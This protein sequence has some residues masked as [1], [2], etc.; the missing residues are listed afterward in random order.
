MPN[1]FAYI[2]L[3]AWPA[4]ALVL[5]RTLP[6]ERALVWSFMA[7]YMV[8]PEATS[9]DPPLIPPLD[10]SS[11]TNISAFLVCILVMGQKVRILPVSGLGKILIILYIVSPFATIMTNTD[12]F[13]LAV[14]PVFPGMKPYDAIAMIT[15]Q[16]IYMM[17]F[18]LGRQYLATPTAQRELLMAFVVGGLVYSLPVLVEVRLSP[19]VHIWIYGFLQHDWFAM[20]RGGGYRPIV[21]MHHGIWLALWMMMCAVSAAILMK[22]AD[23]ERRAFYMGSMIYLAVILALCKSLGALVYL[24]FLLPMILLTTRKMQLHVAAILVILVMS[25]PLLRG[26]GL[27]PVDTLLDIA[28]SLSENRMLSLQFRFDNE[29]RL[30]A[31]AQERAVFG[32]GG[33]GRNHVFDPE[34]GRNISV[35]D[36]RWLAVFGMFGW[37]GYFA[38]FGLLVL[39]VLLLWRV[40]R[41]RGIDALSPYAPGLCLMYAVNVLDLLP[42]ATLVPLTWLMA[43]M[44]L[45]YAERLA[46]QG[47]KAGT[48]PARPAEPEAEQV[49]ARKP[50]P[51]KR[52]RRGAPLRDAPGAPPPPDPDPASGARHVRRKRPAR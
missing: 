8:L 33:F 39:P 18:F 42:N 14:G 26:M 43:G 29:D 34:T 36:G 31:H 35:I 50:E 30:L 46:G 23:K 21:L 44:I 19:R 47:A 3:F 9:V 7:A 5:Y 32:W 40:S 51:R 48:E 6:F 37:A 15:Q 13:A 11:M 12:P 24:V 25:Y 49:L 16:L 10:K 1:T 17:P 52:R 45:G 41:T 20:L 27:I 4:I 28:G 38:E 2:M 22:S